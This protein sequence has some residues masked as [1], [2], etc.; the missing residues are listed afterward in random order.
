MAVQ[1]RCIESNHGEDTS[2]VK[3]RASVSPSPCECHNNPL[4]CP[5]PRVYV[6]TSTSA[7]A[8]PVTSLESGHRSSY[9]AVSIAAIPPR[10]SEP[11]SIVTK[12]EAVD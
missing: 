9:P 4:S 12:D 11:T 3:R 5:L 6:A 8:D 1:M 7:A 10:A 2:K